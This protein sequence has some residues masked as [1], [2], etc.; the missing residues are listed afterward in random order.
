[1]DQQ[2]SS[3]RIVE[4]GPRDGLQNI[5]DSVPTPTK[6]E[7]IRRLR[8][9]GLST[10]ELTSV[11][12]PRAVPQLKDC[13]E[14]LRD[15]KVKNLLQNSRLRLPVL[16]PNEK[17]FKI[18]IEHGV[19]EVAVFVSATEGFSKANINCTVQEG[20]ERA[21]R[22]AA[23]A[24]ATNGA[25]ESQIAVRGYVSCIFA[26]PFDG[27]TPH[28]A[29]LHCVQQ[30]LQAGC[31][32]ISLG[33]TLGVGSPSNVRNLLAYLKDNNIPL[34]RLAG[35]F[36]DTYGQAVANVWE[37]Y[38]CGL[39]VFDSSV[40]G[41]GG[42]PFAPGAKGN[43]ATED[44]V[45]MFDNAGISTGVDLARL[46][47]VGTWI[48]KQL[49]RTNS[50]RVGTAL[51]IKSSTKITAF[52]NS[53]PG[54]PLQWTLISETDGL[55]L[56]RSGV[57][58]K[59]TLNRPKNGNALTTTM[60]SDITK[61]VTGANYDAGISRIVVTAN[62]KFFCTGMDLGKDST[63]VARG[64]SASDAQYA[65]LT[66]LFEAIDTSPKVTIAAINGPTFGGGVGLAFVCDIRIATSS[67]VM[68]LSEVKL[69]LCPAT[70]SKYVIREYGL[71]FAK[72]V[73]LSARPVKASE[74]KTRG[75]ITDTV[76]NVE[77][78]N[79]RLDALLDALK[80]A[81]PNASRMSKELIRL[82]WKD[83]G[84]EKQAAGIKML[85]DEMMRPDADGAHG[86]REFGLKRKVDWDAHTLQQGKP[87][88]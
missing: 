85:F 61:A 73:M 66:G 11:V 53:Q 80:I 38:T 64:G 62:G 19:R 32:E 70:I 5:H 58:L 50:S 34:A 65:R 23:L 51:M 49:S 78:L 20:I 8:E 41:L 29:V 10:I 22:V 39:T 81:S 14:I 79:L 7:L 40:S 33:D 59:I 87:K 36:H 37:A 76:G 69:G 30:L 1:M 74:L 13:R 44:L 48:S 63:P 67:T 3:V 45:Y 82:A 27:P 16:V 17:G 52:S 12:S 46:T 18:A 56:H 2:S 86:L 68:T 84:G 31:Y 26:D 42:C 83:G 28:S 71:S 88:L 77:Q 43:V 15:T 21:K 72:E 57:N 60:I 24:S 4:V 55:L 75:I 47:E 25:G 35:H 54:K 9:T 6:L